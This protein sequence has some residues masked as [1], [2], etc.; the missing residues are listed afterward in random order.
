MSIRIMTAVW[1][2]PTQLNPTARLVLLSLADQANDDGWCW[3]SLAS[4]GR[5]CGV[6]EDTVRR[7]ITVLAMTG[8]VERHPREGRS[9]MYR[10]TPGGAATPSADATPG[11]TATPTPSV[12]AT[13]PL[14]PVLPEPSR[15]PQ[16]EPSPTPPPDGGGTAWRALPVTDDDDERTNPYDV[17]VSTPLPGMPPEEVTRTAGDLVAAWVDGY[18]ERRGTAPLRSQVKRMASSAKRLAADL[19]GLTDPR[20]WDAGLHLARRAGADAHLDLVTAIGRYHERAGT[21]AWWVTLRAGQEL[22]Q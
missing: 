17:L 7:W 20:A 2:T 12:G 4:T 13:P 22:E 6:S 18:R 16:E 1:D 9:T 19:D 21:T 8:L 14:A 3:P 5:R 11:V 10:V 15:N